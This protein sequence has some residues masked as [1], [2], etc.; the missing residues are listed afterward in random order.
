MLSYKIILAVTIAEFSTKGLVL[1]TVH[2][3]F[4]QIGFMVPIM[5]ITKMIL[6]KH[7]I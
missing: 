4:D 6:Q 7:G 2:R 3:G 1:K 5:Q